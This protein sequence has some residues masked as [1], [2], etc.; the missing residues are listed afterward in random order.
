MLNNFEILAAKCIEAAKA[1]LY[2]E[3][4][5]LRARHSRDLGHDYADQIRV[6]ERLMGEGYVSLRESR[7]ELNKLVQSEWLQD[8]LSHA[9]TAAWEI[10]DA[11]PERKWKFNPDQ[12]KGNF[13]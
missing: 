10:A 3:E 7:L 9:N 1:G 12:S 2:F 4:F 8:G 5:K 11:F 13:S 6:L